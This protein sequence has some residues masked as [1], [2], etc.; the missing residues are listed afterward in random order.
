VHQFI[1]QQV[2]KGGK[3]RTNFHSSHNILYLNYASM[4]IVKETHHTKIL[5]WVCKHVQRQ[6]TSLECT[7]SQHKKQVKEV[8]KEQLYTHH[9]KS[10]L[11]YA[12][13]FIQ[14]QLTSW[15]CTSSQHS[16]WVKEVSKEQFF[17]HHSKSY[18]KYAN[19]FIQRQLTS[20]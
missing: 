7:S 4:F 16:K 5:S 11:V 18:L 13:M 10:Y 3:E 8:K 20:W 6:L 17:T 1:A 9:S 2:G 14:K 12:N 19:M 15:E